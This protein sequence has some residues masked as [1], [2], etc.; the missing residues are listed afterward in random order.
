M[1]NKCYKHNIPTL[2][3]QLESQDIPERKRSAYNYVK[4][5]LE[6]MGE[7]WKGSVVFD[8]KGNISAAAA[9]DI[10]KGRTRV[11]TLGSIGAFEKGVTPGMSVL[12]DIMK[13]SQ[14]VGNG[15]IVL[16]STPEAVDFY[17]KYEFNPDNQ[18][19]R[20]MLAKKGDYINFVNWFESFTG[21]K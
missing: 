7:G 8:S 20:R 13:Q 21:G 17:A 18:D 10:F 3:S 6:L 5:S 15:D 1:S 2:L 9:Y 14:G 12:Y 16:Y 4:R 19:G 11:E